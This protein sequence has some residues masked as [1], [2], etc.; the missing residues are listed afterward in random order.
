MSDSKCTRKVA[1]SKIF[2][3]NLQ[4]WAT[5]PVYGA[6]SVTYGGTFCQWWYSSCYHRM[7]SRAC[8]A[9]RKDISFIVVI[10]YEENKSQI[11]SRHIIFLLSMHNDIF[12]GTLTAGAIGGEPYYVFSNPVASALKPFFKSHSYCVLSDPIHWVTKPA[13]L[14]EDRNISFFTGNLCYLGTITP[15]TTF[16]AF[17]TIHIVVKITIILS[18]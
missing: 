11:W 9:R 16:W 8:L 4:K 18:S 7:P 6:G 14:D 12:A 5:Y 10:N 17:M 1:W 2:R 13:P 3:Q 15:S